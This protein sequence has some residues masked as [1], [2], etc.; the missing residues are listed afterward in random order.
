MSRHLQTT[1]RFCSD[2]LQDPV[3]I[4]LMLQCD[5]LVAAILYNQTCL[6]WYR[7]LLRWPS[8][9]SLLWSLLMVPVTLITMTCLK[10]AICLYS[11]QN[12]IDGFHCT[13]NSVNHSHNSVFLSFLIWSDECDAV[14]TGIYNSGHLSNTWRP[15]QHF[16]PK[17]AGNNHNPFRAVPRET[18]GRQYTWLSITLL[19]LFYIRRDYY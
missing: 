5:D 16:N 8:L 15:C 19:T 3:I 6:Y 2:S 7:S 17:S 13:V 10:A 14:W 11:S 1:F 9:S 4:I 18:A 12:T